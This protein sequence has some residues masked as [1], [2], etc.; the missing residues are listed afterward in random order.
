MKRLSLLAALVATLSLWDVPSGEASPPG[1]PPCPRDLL[2]GCPN[3]YCRKPWPRI[4][5]LSGGGP[6]DY[7]RK[8]CP[9]LWTLGHCNL[10]NDYDRKPC[11]NLCRP[12]CPDHYTCGCPA[13][14][15]PVLPAPAPAI[16]RQDG[17]PCGYNNGQM[18]SVSPYHP[19]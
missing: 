1:A 10:P 13:P 12:L 14:C 9:R 15:R 5:C 18:R 2:T 7:C 11:P 4:W 3:D 17:G 8:L 19:R 16:E 6:D